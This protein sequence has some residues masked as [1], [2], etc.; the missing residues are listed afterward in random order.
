MTAHA[1]HALRK[2][3]LQNLIAYPKKNV[4]K[5]IVLFYESERD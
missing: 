4:G 2:K 5:K 1:R 3:E